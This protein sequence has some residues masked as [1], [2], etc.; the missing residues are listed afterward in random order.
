MP[1][2]KI[3]PVA[4]C[5]HP[6]DRWYAWTVYDVVEALRIGKSYKFTLCVGCCQCGKVLQGGKEL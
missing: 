6:K 4:K 1:K 2:K 3:V 5:T